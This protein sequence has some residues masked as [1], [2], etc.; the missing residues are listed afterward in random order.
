VVAKSTGWKEILD[1][2]WFHFSLQT[3]QNRNEFWLDK[4]EKGIKY[5]KLQGCYVV[6]TSR[7]LP[8]NVCNS[9]PV[10]MPSHAIGLEYV[11]ALLWE[12]QIW[13]NGICFAVEKKP[14]YKFCFSRCPFRTSFTKDI[15]LS[16]IYFCSIAMIMDSNF[17]NAIPTIEHKNRQQINLRARRWRF[18]LKF[19]IA[20]HYS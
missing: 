18:L 9:L 15:I 13:Q 2:S 8:R 12:P 17:L 20:C 6:S 4:K 14:F 10:D 3:A 11:S 5:S 16:G 7:E 19:K 1:H